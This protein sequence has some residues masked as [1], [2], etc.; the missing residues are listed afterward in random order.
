VDPSYQGIRLN[1]LPK[2]EAARAILLCARALHSHLTKGRPLAGALRD[3]LSGGR[4]DAGTREAAAA[5]AHSA[6]AR[7]TLLELE[8]RAADSEPPPEEWQALRLAGAALAWGPSVPGLGRPEEHHQSLLEIARALGL[9]SPER[10]LAFL[11]RADGPRALLSYPAEEENGSLALRAGFPELVVRH[12][13]DSQGTAAARNLLSYLNGPAPLHLR[14]SRPAEMDR[15]IEALAREGAT[16]RVTGRVEGALLVAEGDVRRS[17]SLA[18]GEIEVQDE[19]SQLVARAAA[20]EG[21]GAVLDFC[22]G[23][24]GKALALASMPGVEVA[25]HDA[26]KSRLETLESR[27]AELGLRVR[28]L[29]LA[30]PKEF[31]SVLADAPCSGL[32]AARRNP[33]AR[34]RATPAG[35]ARLSSVQS[36]IL[37][38][39]ASRVRPG[40]TLVYAVCT[41]L[42]EECEAVVASFLSGHSGFSADPAPVWASKLLAPRGQGFTTFPAMR[43]ADVFFTAFLRRADP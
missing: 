33:E 37:A 20:P 43:G 21:G 31:D 22:A 27:A 15:V 2:T 28:R 10:R 18:S 19:A 41:F 38:E 32:G 11:K 30:V 36:G 34:W 17:A 6:V 3:A 39:A 4:K 26:D 9:G 13:I 8:L 24:G 7:R 16:A 12:L 14:V 1:E 25:A 5:L 40:G 29:D 23:S 35:I 42:E